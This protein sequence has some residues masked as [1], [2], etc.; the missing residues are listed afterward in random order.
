LLL[1]EEARALW[2]KWRSGGFV[3]QL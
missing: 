2:T 3:L 1:E